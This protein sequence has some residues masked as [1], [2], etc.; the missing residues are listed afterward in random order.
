MNVIPGCLR[1]LDPEAGPEPMDTSLYLVVDGLCPW[2]PGSR[3]VPAP[4]NDSV[5]GIP[6][7]LSRRR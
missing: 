4:R 1:A 5:W 3:A 6:Y 7:G 2:L